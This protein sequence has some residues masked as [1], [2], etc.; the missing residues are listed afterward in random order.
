MISKIWRDHRALVFILIAFLALAI[1][2]SIITPIFEAG[3]EI[4]H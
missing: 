3:D 4:W 2:Y 1:T